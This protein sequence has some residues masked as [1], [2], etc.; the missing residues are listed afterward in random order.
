MLDVEA[1]WMKDSVGAT[2]DYYPLVIPNRKRI[3]LTLSKIFPLMLHDK[4]FFFPFKQS[5]ALKLYG[6][7]LTAIA[8]FAHVSE[9]H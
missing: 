9:R 1:S 4:V 2:D 6:Q 8:T 3:K 7:Q 5:S